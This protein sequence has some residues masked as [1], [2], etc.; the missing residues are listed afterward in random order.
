MMRPGIS[1]RTSPGRSSGR[2][3]ICSWLMVPV[4]AE[5]AWPTRFAFRP[6]VT[7]PICLSPPAHG[8]GNAAG[9][10]LAPGGA[11]ETPVGK[12]DGH[13]LGSAGRDVGTALTP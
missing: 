9:A 4:D 3:A 6:T 8:V 5:I 10:T 1:S 11:P 13:V 12:L 7:R 2:V